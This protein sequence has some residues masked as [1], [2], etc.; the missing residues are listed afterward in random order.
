MRKQPSKRRW[1]ARADL[2]RLIPLEAIVNHR[3]E[4]WFL[5]EADARSPWSE[6][7]RLRRHA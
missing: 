1:K 7:Y 2:G 5:F 4:R 3:L 6:F